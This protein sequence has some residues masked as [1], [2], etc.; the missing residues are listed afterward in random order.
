MRNELLLIGAILI[1]LIADL[2]IDKPQKHLVYQ[3]SLLLMFVVT[4]VSFVP[5]GEGSLFG[6][7]YVSGK[8]QMVMTS[9]PSGKIT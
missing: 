4:I 3:I 9:T 6:G 8:I 7:M 2:F 5:A 1:V